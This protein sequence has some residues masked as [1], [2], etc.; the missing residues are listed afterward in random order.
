MVDIFTTLTK[1]YL[2]E[3]KDITSD[4]RVLPKITAVN[5]GFVSR[6]KS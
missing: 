2:A 6:S 1:I 5:N 4:P 3:I